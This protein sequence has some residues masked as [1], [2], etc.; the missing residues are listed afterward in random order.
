MV[1]HIIAASHTWVKMKQG[2]ETGARLFHSRFSAQ[3]MRNSVGEKGASKQSQ[4]N[5][6]AIINTGV[7]ETSI[8]TLNF[9]TF[10]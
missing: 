10:V 5:E 1:A 2:Y 7:P 4:Q 9:C 8:E 3:T 6:E